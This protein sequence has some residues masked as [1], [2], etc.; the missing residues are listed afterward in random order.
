MIIYNLLLRRSDG[1]TE[2]LEFVGETP[3]GAASAAVRKASIARPS[4]E[5]VLVT[6][7]NMVWIPRYDDW[8]HLLPQH[9]ARNLPPYE[10]EG[11][12][13]MQAAQPK[14]P[15]VPDKPLEPPH[16]A[17]TELAAPIVPKMTVGQARDAGFTGNTCNDCGS[18]QMVRNGTCEKCNSCGATTGCS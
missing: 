1:T 12:S 15:A 13:P 16:V 4:V 17:A 9:I 10:F 2:P 8:L 3:S 5:A 14:A 11:Y 7:I 6:G 18:L